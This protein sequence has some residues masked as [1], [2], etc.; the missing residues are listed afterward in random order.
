MGDPPRLLLDVVHV[1]PREKGC[2]KREHKEDDADA[3][4]DDVMRCVFGLEDLS[5]VP[6]RRGQ[7]RIPD[8]IGLEE[9]LTAR[10]GWRPCWRKRT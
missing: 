4:G 2:E 9:R 1:I 6:A 7:L 3:V 5:G 10:E 8:E